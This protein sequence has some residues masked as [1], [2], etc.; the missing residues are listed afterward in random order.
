MLFLFKFLHFFPSADDALGDEEDEEES[1]AIVNQVLDELG[2]QL[3]DDLAGVAGVPSGSLSVANPGELSFVNITYSFII[4]T[5]LHEIFF[6][7]VEYSS[8]P[9]HRLSLKW[10]Y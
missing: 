4:L 1:D 8:F 3:T 2:L 7:F 5:S 9:S 6:I 10:F